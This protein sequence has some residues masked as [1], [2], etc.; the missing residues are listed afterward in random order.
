MCFDAA[1]A[2]QPWHYMERRKSIKR[3][4]S[5]AVL[6][7]WSWVGWAGDLNSESWRS[8]ANYLLEPDDEEHP[9][10]QCSWKTI[11][12]VKWNYSIS[13][14]SPHKEIYIHAQ[15]LHPVFNPT[16]EPLPHGWSS[17]ADPSRSDQVLYYHSSD[18]SH[19]FRY[20]IPIRD[21]HIAHIPPISARYLHCTTAH[22]FLKLGSAYQSIASDCP[23]VELMAEDGRWAGVLRLN[24]MPW[25]FAV[26][27]E[28]V[29]TK[30][31]GLVE[32]I[33]IS[34]GSVDSPTLEEKSF[35]E[36]N[37]EG[38]PRQK[39][40]YEF[41]NVLW[42]EWVDRVAYRKTLEGLRK[43]FGKRLPQSGSMLRWVE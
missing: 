36:W 2:W 40:P 34:A 1:L 39:G 7:S 6:P 17:R 5:D 43:T 31:R 24:C 30:N 22:A 20:P 38:C 35:D 9:G 37:R 8:A 26:L 11:S 4:I 16:S 3:S 19:P 42:V 15:F 14:T 23:A 21:Q 29:K 41:F 13:R 33:E 12:T 28:E 32:L 10:Q 27:I 25:D 18:P